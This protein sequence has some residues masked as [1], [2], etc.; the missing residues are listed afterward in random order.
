MTDR[1]QWHLDKRVPIALIFA[2][3]VQSASA[4]WWAAGI[5]E[6]MAQIERRQASQGERS[7]AADRLMAEQGQRIAVL[8]EAV[9]NT[10]RNLERLQAEIG[11]TNALLR[12]FLFRQPDSGG[13]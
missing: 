11:S 13:R 3:M 10:N 5:S 6:R 4:I 12:E 7:E 9:S 1:E 2:I 8:T